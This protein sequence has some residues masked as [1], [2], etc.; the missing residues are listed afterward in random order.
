MSGAIS[1]LT[2]GSYG[3]LQQLI[4]NSSS[5]YAKLDQLT[6]QASTGYVA[7]TYAGLDTATTGSASGAL[8]IA[9]QIASIDN[10]VTNL[11]TVAG[12]MNVQQSTITTINQIASTALSQFQTVSALS[13]Q[14]MGTAASTARQ[15][16]VQIASLLNSQDGSAYIFGGQNSGTA[17]VSN[18]NG[19]TSSAFFTTIQTAVSNLSTS[20]AAVTQSSVLGAALANT[21][22]NAAIG[23]SSGLPQVAGAD[24]AM[25]TTGIAA[26]S[27][28]F[29]TSTGPNTTGSYMGDILTNLAAIASLTPGQVGAPAFSSFAASTIG[30]LTNALNTMAQDAGTLG[31]NQAL[32]ATQSTN[33]QQTSTA[34]S[35]QL[36][37]FDQVNMTSTLANL[38]S[39]QTQLQASYQLI[40]AMKTM[41]LTQYI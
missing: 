3:L 27:N 5:T 15:A 32:L 13:P 30:S 35:T 4:G 11:N 39:T 10:S 37:G 16:L 21:P 40:A 22:F 23:S 29:V 17:P 28:A 6:T 25:I 36:A 14:G 38:S 41:S 34:L 7:G 20:G 12:R 9:P 26:T 1:G 2:G 24:G 31:N 19:I 8:A 18:P 33:L